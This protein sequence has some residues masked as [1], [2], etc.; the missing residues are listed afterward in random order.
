MPV[1]EKD[2]PVQNGKPLFVQL[3]RVWMLIFQGM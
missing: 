2:F 1:A 3:G